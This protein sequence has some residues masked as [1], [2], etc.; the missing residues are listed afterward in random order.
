MN[1]FSKILKYLFLLIIFLIFFKTD[2]RFTNE[3]LCCGDDFDYYA[4]AQTLAEDYDL[5]YSNQLAGYEDRR[6]NLNGKVAPKGFFG[7]GLL[8]SP[9][10]FLGNHVDN[11][12]KSLVNFKYVELMN[13]SILIYSLSSVTFVFLTCLL[14][15]KSLNILKIQI[16]IFE[17]LLVYSASGVIYF[18]FERFSMAH[19]YE[20]FTISLLI[21]LSVKHYKINTNFTV[22][23]IPLAIL[24]VFLVRMVNYYALFIPLI[25]SYIV[26]K[27]FDFKLY[28]HPKFLLSTAIS[29]FIYIFLSISIYGIIT[30]NPQTMYGTSGLLGGFFGELSFYEFLKQNLDFG[31]L[32]L[33]GQEF[34]ILWFSPIL[35]FGLISSFF[36]SKKL[37]IFNN[38]LFVSPYI[39]GIGSVLL[40]KSAASSYGFRYLYSLV[41]ISIVYFYSLKNNDKFSFYRKLLLFLSV[42]ALVSILFFE[43][44][45]L[46]QLSTVEEMNSFGRNIKYVERYYLKGYLLALINFESYLKIFVTS[47]FGATVFKFIFIRVSIDDFINFLASLNLPVKNDDFIEYLFE[48]QLI[49]LN[50]FIF[51][52]LYFLIFVHIF[53]K[54]LKI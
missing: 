50:K 30:I 31:L 1:N 33:F 3:I 35:F 20:T 24:L 7:S 11:F 19:V 27:K 43:T 16:S 23:F 51:V 45:E 15:H 9:F 17:I 53:F 2:Y 4:H 29:I 26:K 12:Y 13:Y 28:M 5:D 49:S 39:L 32:I 47:F 21:L 41:P 18:A 14:I 34:G 6:F 44:T 25:I 38:L 8:A 42:F 10:L 54:K 37:N 52:I 48:I 46:T 36:I 40:W 22:F